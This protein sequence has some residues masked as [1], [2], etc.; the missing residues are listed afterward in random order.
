[1]NAQHQQGLSDAKSQKNPKISLG[2]IQVSPTSQA[3]WGLL[4][5][6]VGASVTRYEPL[7]CG[8]PGVKEGAMR[9]LADHFAAK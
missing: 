5:R 2:G 1:M 7:I 4:I 8:N 9:S 3:G 6:D